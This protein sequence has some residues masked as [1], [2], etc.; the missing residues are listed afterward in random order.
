MVLTEGSTITEGTQSKRNAS[1]WKECRAQDGT[2]ILIVRLPLRQYANERSGVEAN[3][4]ARL[5]IEL[6]ISV[7]DEASGQFR[8]YPRPPSRGG[9]TRVELGSNYG[10]LPP[11]YRLAS[12]VATLPHRL[13]VVSWPPGHRELDRGDCE[14]PILTVP[15]LSAR[16]SPQ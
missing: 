12:V 2:S 1:P 14:F 10:T 15:Y 3:S 13:V 8:D 5:T 9:L 7:K 16:L 11:S 4:G 6:P